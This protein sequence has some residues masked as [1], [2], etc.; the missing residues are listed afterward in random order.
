MRTD[1]RPIKT[2]VES[3]YTVYYVGHETVPIPQQL[4]KMLHQL[5]FSFLFTI[6]FQ[7]NA[8]NIPKSITNEY[9]KKFKNY[10]KMSIKLYNS[11]KAQNLHT[12]PKRPLNQEA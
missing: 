4:E 5:G 7:S 8:N 3:L 9:K 2:K 1:E 6:F 12:R 11:S 10:I